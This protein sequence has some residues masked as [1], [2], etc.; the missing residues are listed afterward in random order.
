MARHGIAEQNIVSEGEH[1]GPTQ[2]E[3]VAALNACSTAIPTPP[4]GSR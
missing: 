2:A 3:V 4:P 1:G